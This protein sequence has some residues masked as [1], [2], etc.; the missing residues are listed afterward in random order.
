[1]NEFANAV[2]LGLGRGCDLVG[3][4]FVGEAEG[5]AEGVADEGFGE[6][7][8][9]VRFTFGNPVAQFEIIGEGRAFVEGSGGVDFPGLVCLPIPSSFSPIDSGGP[10]FTR[11]IKVLKAKSNGI[12]LAMATG[13]L[14]FFLVGGQLFANGERFIGQARKL[15]NIRRRRRR[16]II[17]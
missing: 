1:M 5:T 14:G 4:I 13:A 12:D 10:P 15:R 8:G 7:A 16:R 2:L 17:Q 11:G 3:E 9:K 6:A